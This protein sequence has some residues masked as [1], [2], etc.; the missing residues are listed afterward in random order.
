M[1]SVFGDFERM[2]GVWAWLNLV[3]FFLLLR[4]LRDQDWPWILNSALAVSLFVGVSVISQHGELAG[5]APSDGLVAGSSSTVGNS[6]L[7]AAYLLMNLSLAAYLACAS[8]RNRVPSMLTDG[9]N[10]A[11]MAGFKDRPLLGYGPENHNIV[12]SRHFDPNIYLLDTDVYDRTHNQFLEVLATNGIVGM[13]AFLG[14]WVAIGMTLVRGYRAGRLS[15][16]AASVLWG[17][18]ID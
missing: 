2:G 9:G 1:H 5:S 3:L 4:T 11:A 10:F 13:V 8:V 15:A 7:L 18:Q 17:L 6:G 16:P 14:I 12:W